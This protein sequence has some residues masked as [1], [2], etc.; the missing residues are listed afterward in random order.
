MLGNHGS[1][2]EEKLPTKIKNSSE[3]RI[4][5]QN[6]LNLNYERG[7]SGI[8]HKLFIAIRCIRHQEENTKLTIIR[9]F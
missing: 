3:L 7:V 5:T 4:K 9:I 8:Y 2:N 1:I 6:I